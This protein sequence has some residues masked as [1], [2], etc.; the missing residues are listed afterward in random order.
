M[1]ESNQKLR[2]EA[3]QDILT[4]VPHWM[5]MWGNTIMLLL[6]VLVFVLAS[7]IEYP[8]VIEVNVQVT[9]SNSKQAGMEGGQQLMAQLEVPVPKA[10]QVV[11]G[12][13]VHIKLIQYPHEDYGVLKGQIPSEYSIVPEQSGLFKIY[14][15]LGNKLVTF[16]GIEIPF[17]KA[18]YGNGEIFTEKVSLL[19][20]IFYRLK[21]VFK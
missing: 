17:D 2:S 20:R 10:S 16:R 8:D 21:D 12:Q 5:I 11:A 19:D 1:P 3:V 15:P 13:T 7:I 4:K 18:M 9:F 6:V 14:V